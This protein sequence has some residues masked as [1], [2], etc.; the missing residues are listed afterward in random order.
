MN[1]LQQTISSSLPSHLRPIYARSI[2]AMRDTTLNKAL[3]MCGAIH[4]MEEM[5]AGRPSPQIDGMR[6]KE[7]S[8]RMLMNRTAS[9]YPRLPVEVIINA[10]RDWDGPYAPYKIAGQDGPMRH[11]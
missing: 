1:N 9:T 11:D 4:A 2:K 10:P 7:W 3:V 5:S 8:A 6:H